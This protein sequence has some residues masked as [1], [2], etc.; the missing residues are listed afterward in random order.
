MQIFNIDL[1][2]SNL[3]QN[4]EAVDACKKII[5]ENLEVNGGTLK[6]ADIFERDFKWSNL[7]IAVVDNQI[8][9]F[10]L[11]RSSENTHNLKNV[12]AYYYLSDIIVK[13]D[14]RSQGIGSALLE[15][16]LSGIGD[17]PLVASVLRGNIPSILLLSKYMKCYSASNSGK[18]LRFVDSK[19]YH[20]IYG[21]AENDLLEGIRYK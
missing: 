2:T 11:V 14:F 9:G 3:M 5:D 6:V 4:K 13:K 18:Y 7:I 10:S 16:A 17:M 21:D 8:V 1:V 15:T 12:D 19:T 20:R